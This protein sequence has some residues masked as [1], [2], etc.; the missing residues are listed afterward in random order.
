[1]IRLYKEIYSDNPVSLR[2]C[3]VLLCEDNHLNAEIA[4]ILLNE[5]G[6]TVEW[7]ENGLTAVQ[8]FKSSAPGYYDA[9]LMDIRMPYMNGYEATKI[10]RKLQGYES[11]KIPIIAMTADAFDEDI[12][13]TKKVGMDDF[14]TKPIQP[15]ALISVLMKNIKK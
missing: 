4:K 5:Q 1:M 6:I 13:K 7:A 8:K 10:I 11:N 15:A 14:L 3:R 12:K 9:I 2:G